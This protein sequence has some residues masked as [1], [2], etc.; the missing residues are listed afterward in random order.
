MTPRDV[1]RAHAAGRLF[2]GAL[3]VGAPEVVGV[4]WLGRDARRRSAHVYSAALGARD[5]ALGAG[6]IAATTAGAGARPWLLAGIASDAVDLV[7]TWRNRA[8][9]PR[10]GVLGTIAFAAP[11]VA[12]GAWL[13]GRVDQP[14]G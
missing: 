3:L 5:A 1:A 8:A 7:A 14:R 4:P 2:F 12:L 13:Q 11:S 6:V 9:L 10:L